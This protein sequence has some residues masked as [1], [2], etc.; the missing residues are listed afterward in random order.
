MAFT[1]DLIRWKSVEVAWCLCTLAPTLAPT[2]PV[3]LAHIRRAAR[4]A[5]H[6]RRLAQCSVSGR[7]RPRG[8]HARGQRAVARGLGIGRC[9]IKRIIDHPT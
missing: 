8:R 7:S 1:W 5:S 9:T 3:G 4:P 2:T 6:G